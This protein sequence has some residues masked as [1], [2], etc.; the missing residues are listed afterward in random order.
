MFGIL[1]RTSLNF[2]RIC[3]Y[4]NSTTKKL[5]YKRF[6]SFQ[7]CRFLFWNVLKSVVLIT[8]GKNN[9]SQRRPFQRWRSKRI[10]VKKKKSKFDFSILPPP[11]PPP[12]TTIVR[13][14]EE[15]NDHFTIDIIDIHIDEPQIDGKTVSCTCV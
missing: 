7:H 4:Q 1:N 10:S 13:L 15:I 2:P 14:V 5:K 3:L 6:P 12:N 8:R 11:F 9:N